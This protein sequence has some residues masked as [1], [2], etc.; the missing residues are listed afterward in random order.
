[1]E[2]NLLSVNDGKRQPRSHNQSLFA[3]IILQASLGAV[4]HR[5]QKS[6]YA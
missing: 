2:A 3:E 1:M 4:C 5:E 6:I